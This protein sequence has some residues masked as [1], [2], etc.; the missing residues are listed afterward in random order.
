[1]RRLPASFNTILSMDFLPV[2]LNIKDKPCLVVG[3]GE[4]AARKA[5]L[6]LK[7]G[8]QVTVLAPDLGSTMSQLAAQGKIVHRAQKLNMDAVGSFDLLNEYFLIIVGA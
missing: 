8:G 3:G 5:R 7:A 1:M 4:V 2:F 6:L